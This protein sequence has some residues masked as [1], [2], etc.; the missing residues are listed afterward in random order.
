[1]QHVLRK[2]GSEQGDGRRGRH[3][4]SLDICTAH[5]LSGLDNMLM[6]NMLYYLP[7]IVKPEVKA[8]DR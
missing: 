1:L 3:P 2:A 4:F 5:S 8:R 6:V 7:Y